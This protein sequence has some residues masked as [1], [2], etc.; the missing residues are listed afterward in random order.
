MY[1]GSRR[2]AFVLTV[3]LGSLA[4]A[5]AFE[6]APGTATYRVTQNTKAAQD[7]MGQKQEIESTSNQVV[8]VRLTRASRD[9][10]AMDIVLD[11]ISSTN[12]MGMPTQMTDRLMGMKVS[13]RLSPVGAFYSAKGPDD[14]SLPNASTLAQ[15]MG[16]FLPKLRGNLAKGSTWLDTTTAK[17]TQGGME[18]ER[19]TVSRYTVEGDTLVGAERAV[20]LARRDSTTMTGSGNGPNGPMTMEGTTTGTGAILVSPKGLF[21]GATGTENANLKIVIAA[22]GME[23][24][25][26][27]NAT[28]KVEKIR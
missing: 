22:N 10:V 13:A 1:A 24:G 19:K 6:Y 26:T 25:V 5:Q 9:T 23:I 12:S 7:I 18:I 2:I 27:Q 16:N 14:T 20:R 17:I 28:T 21:L 4:Q 8:S 3:A 11:S 15:A